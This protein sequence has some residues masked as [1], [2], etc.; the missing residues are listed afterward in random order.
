MARPHLALLLLCLLGGFS[1][2]RAYPASR[3]SVTL[4][5]NVKM[6]A[7]QLVV[8]LDQYLKRLSLEEW[9]QSLSASPPLDPMDGLASLVLV[10]DGYESVISERLE[11]L[12]QVRQEV[13]SLRGYLE[14]WRS[15]HCAG[16]PRTK[17]APQGRLARL[18]GYKEYP[19]TVGLEGVVGLKDY[20]VQ[21]LKHLDLLGAC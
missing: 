20:L 9:S 18:Q 13:S 10:L 4:R 15:G 21:L 2:A 17:Q 19:Q 7:E 5:A 11:G 6:N 3:E 1:S 8:R 16:P 14:D 12:A